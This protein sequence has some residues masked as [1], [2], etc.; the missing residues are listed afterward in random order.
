MAFFFCLCYLLTNF[1]H[2]GFSVC[3]QDLIMYSHQTVHLFVWASLYL[4]WCKAGFPPS[5]R[6]TAVWQPPGSRRV[7]RWA[8][9]PASP[10]RSWPPLA[11]WRSSTARHKQLE[12]SAGT[13]P[14]QNGAM[15]S[16]LEDKLNCQY[17]FFLWLKPL[18]HSQNHAKIC[19]FYTFS[20]QSALQNVVILCVSAVKLNGKNCQ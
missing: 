7:R 11:Q 2:I 14:R 18:C 5:W 8:G 3:L 19:M 6:C 9:C 1:S 13:P 4:G 15:I 17:F 16:H 12:T 20:T 10:W